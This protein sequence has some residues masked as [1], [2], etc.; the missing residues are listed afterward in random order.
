MTSEFDSLY[1][2][3][4]KA[5]TNANAVPL[6][7]WLANICIPQADEKYGGKFSFKEY[8]DGSD[9]WDKEHRSDL[10]RKYNYLCGPVHH[11]LAHGLGRDDP[12]GDHKI[13][14]TGTQQVI[15][16]VREVLDNLHEVPGD[17]YYRWS[18]ILKEFPNAK[19]ELEPLLARALE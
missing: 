17:T 5:E 8:V 1:E 6:A 11:G 3:F 13:L 2:I 12:L 9:D 18:Y 10:W 7:E 16:L 19:A 4:E 15:I 14:S